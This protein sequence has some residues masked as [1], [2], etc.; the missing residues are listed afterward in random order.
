MAYDANLVLNDGST[1]IT[2]T[3]SSSALNIP[4]GTPRRGLKVRIVVTAVSGTSPTALYEI[5]SCATSGG[6]YATCAT[7]EGGNVTATGEYF[8][9][10]E[11][12][13]PYI[14]LKTT[15]GGT[16]PSFTTYAH[17]VDSRP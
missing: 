10:F 14:K 16:S 11:T 9:P 15:V 8:I 6:T 17:V 4:S 3:G 13:K 7:Y 1:A 5:Q 2:S 12:S